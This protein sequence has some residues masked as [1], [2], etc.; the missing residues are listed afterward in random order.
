M[1]RQL[2]HLLLVIPS[3]FALSGI[4]VLLYLLDAKFEVTPFIILSMVLA[5][6]FAFFIVP[7]LIFAVRWTV[8]YFGNLNFEQSFR[9]GYLFGCGWA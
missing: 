8:N 6:V 9:L 3:C 4:T 5:S 2:K 7:S 1:N